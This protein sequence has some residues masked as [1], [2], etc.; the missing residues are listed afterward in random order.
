MAPAKQKAQKMSIGTFLADENYGSWADEMDDLPLPTGMPPLLSSTDSRATFGGE[1]RPFSAAPSSFG[2]EHGG[3]AREE[4]PLPTQPPYT[5]HIGNMS[6]D[7]TQAD[8]SDLFAACEVTSVRIVEDKLTRAPKG[9]GYVE[10]A[11]LDGLKKAL[12]F[13]GT[14]FQGRSI[15]VSVAEP[16]KERHD[17]RDLSDWSR[18][19][20]LPDLPQRRPTDRPGHGSRGFDAMSDAGS[21]RAGRRPYEPA[22][23]KMRDFSSWE[24]KG[25]LPAA[26]P[27]VREGRPQSKDGSQFR[28]ASPAWGEGRSQDGS[29]P[30]RREFQER[31]PPERTPTAPELDNQ[32]R[33]R[34]RPDPPA[35]TP[36][37]EA[38]PA[39]PASPVAPTSTA[40]AM[41]PKLNLQKRTVPETETS[42][43][44]SAG[45]S[46]ASPFGAARPIDTA[47]REKEIEEKRLHKKKEAEEKAK[48]EREEQQRLTKEQDLAKEKE[49]EE[50]AAS[51]AASANGSKEGGADVP[52]GVKGFEILQRSEETE[53][54][55]TVTPQESSA[56]PSEE[57]SISP[58]DP[59]RPQPPS[60]A[61]SNWRSAGPR[62]GSNQ[63]QQAARNR[64]P[65]KGSPKQPATPVIDEDGWS[66]VSSKPRGGRRGG[67]NAA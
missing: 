46:K 18:K 43:S 16:P 44:P 67:R 30:P 64:V 9:F 8:I 13:Q 50:A 24:R 49:K 61:N 34:M 62:R 25:P 27:T 52:E 58:R 45:D 26:A 4:L 6:F 15:R 5:A 60:R 35:Q 47:A 63:G 3:Y 57:K 59:N 42:A 54:G 12:T 40:P 66:T 37:V 28:R 11:T 29:R 48:A 19:G 36:A 1:R 51:T 2:Y 20:P 31:P 14:S 33:A 21:E 7:A 38:A 56:A 65:P 39:A 22:D 53:N 17:A 55:E 32:W 41:R 10:F 23:G